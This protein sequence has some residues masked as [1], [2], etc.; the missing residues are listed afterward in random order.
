ML[1]KDIIK[2]EYLIN[3]KNID[4]IKKLDDN[5][6]LNEPNKNVLLTTE[7]NEVLKNSICENDYR[8]NWDKKTTHEKIW[9]LKYV[10]LP[11]N[12]AGTYREIL[13]ICFSHKYNTT[14]YNSLMLMIKK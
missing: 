4:F 9:F 2:K 10:L 1:I 6:F 7:A 14:I 13:K 5:I 3:K 8:I 12:E 11:I